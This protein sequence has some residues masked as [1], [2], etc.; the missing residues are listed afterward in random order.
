MSRLQGVSTSHF[1]VFPQSSDTASSGKIIR[2]ELPN[3]SL[4][5]MKNLRLFFNASTSNGTTNK[6]GRLP[7]DIS[8]LI[9]RVAVYM[10][11]VLVQNS[12]NQYNTLVHAKAAIEGPK[13][14]P[15]L[16]HPE[17]VRA[18]SYHNNAALA[19][20]ADEAYTDVDDAFCISNWEGLLGSIEPS[21][22]DTGLLPQITLE[23]TLADD[24][25][26]STCNDITLA[27]F[28]AGSSNTGTTY[29]LTNLSVQ[30]EVLG[31]ATSVLEQL[32]EQ[33]IASVGYLSLPFKNYFTYQSTHTSTSRF[34]VNS[35]SWDR[36]WVIFRP[37][38]YSTQKEP[39]TARGY[40]VTGG[41]L[42]NA[43]GDTAADI[44]VGVASYD[45]GGNATY[46]T[47]VEKYISNYFKFT[48]PGDANTKYNLQV[49][50]ANVPAY[51]MTSAE[52]LSMTKGAVDMPKNVMSLD[53][54]KTDYFVQCYRFCLPDSDFNRLASGLN[55][56][57]SSPQQVQVGA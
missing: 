19:Q 54:Y 14:E 8:S 13:C 17:I 11:G 39:I 31:M 7:N 35:A 45:I 32:T 24:A 53:Q 33:R 28:V 15:S 6:G 34:N 3:N 37:T 22:I 48:D 52:A 12:F 49:N 20:G 4:V 10:G 47:N 57:T 23:I 41:F 25:V 29:S 51:K 27:G 26:C 46:N 42:D 43:A 38:S 18:K 21:I 16:T 40:K 56:L 2:F 50:S 55:F 30:V 9:E 5:N 1:K 36:L 44:D